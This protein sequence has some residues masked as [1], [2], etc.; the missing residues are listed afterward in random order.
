MSLTTHAENLFPSAESRVRLTNELT[1]RMGPYTIS[2]PERHTF[3]SRDL[4]EY[5][6]KPVQR[7]LVHLK[8]ESICYWG[9][10]PKCDLR[11]IHFPKLKSLELG[12][13][14]FT[15]DWQL[16]WIISHGETLTKLNLRQCSIVHDIWIAHTLDSENY[17]V[18]VLGER[19]DWDQLSAEND[20]KW[21]GNR[22]RWNE[23]FGK[24]TSG[25]PHLQHLKVGNSQ[26][27]DPKFGVAATKSWRSFYCAF[28]SE[29]CFGEWA[30]DHPSIGRGYSFHDDEYLEPQP[31]YPHCK[32]EDLEAL[33]QLM[34][35]VRGRAGLPELEESP[36]TVTPPTQP[37]LPT[38][39]WDH[40][41]VKR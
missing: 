33:E 4:L 38:R 2:E 34:V 17:P 27:S 1:D 31:S 9:W 12:E 3:F 21:C 13:M 7:N 28:W 19:L 23:Y 14:T 25:L 8:L 15:H 20:V 30:G 10:I 39:F 41:G 37:N 11:G 6:L 16:A 26:S 36:F 18:H 35:A 40:P 5:W 32:K 22:A 24:L 29:A